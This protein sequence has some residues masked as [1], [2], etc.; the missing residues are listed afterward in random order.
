[1]LVLALAAQAALITACGGGSD[2]SATSTAARQP[3]ASG[4][5]Q[6]QKVGDFD[7]PDYVT[8]PPGSDDLYVVERQGSVRIVRGGEVVSTPALDIR[9][10]VTSDGEEQGLLSIAF[11]PGLPEL[12]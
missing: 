7:Q 6:L 11:P 12:A 1:V 3:P 9:D 10:R 2:S 8:Q 5:V 4:E